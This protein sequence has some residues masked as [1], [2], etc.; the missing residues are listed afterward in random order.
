[1]HILSIFID[2]T[3]QQKKNFFLNLGQMNLILT[4]FGA[5]NSNLTSEFCYHVKIFKYSF[6]HSF[7]KS[8]FAHKNNQLNKQQK[9]DTLSFPSNFTTSETP[10]C[11]TLLNKLLETHP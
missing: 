1:M 5:L 9:T 11:L 4:N 7:M 8:I 2:Y 6:N 3:G 10:C